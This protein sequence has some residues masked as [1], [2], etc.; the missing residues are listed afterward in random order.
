MNDTHRAKAKPVEGLTLQLADVEAL[1]P[2]LEALHER[3][4][5]SHSPIKLEQVLLDVTSVIRWGVPPE[6]DR[7]LGASDLLR[8]E[9]SVG[10]T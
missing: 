5:S 4:A 10:L 6:V 1:C 8:R 9:W 2:A 7:G 3:R